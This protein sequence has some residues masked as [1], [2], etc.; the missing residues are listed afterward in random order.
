MKEIKNIYMAKIIILSISFLLISNFGFAQEEDTDKLPVRSPWTTSILIDN[1]TTIGPNAKAFD[2]TIHHRF[3]AIKEMSDLFGIYAASNI[4]LG[5]NYGIT[6][7][8]SIGFGTEK[9]NKMQEFQGKYQIISQTRDGKIPVAVT[10]FGNVVI[11]ARD[12]EVFGKNYEFTNRLSFFNQIIVSR[13]FN[14][15]LSMQFAASYSHFNA[16]DSLWKNAYIG[17]MLGG[18]YKISNKV[19]GFTSYL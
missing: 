8:I 9:Y 16:V 10:Y 2:F 12:K 17:L 18:R 14:S 19:V 1:Q 15:K 13:K 3:G 4:R 6:E 5:I 7:K 11:D